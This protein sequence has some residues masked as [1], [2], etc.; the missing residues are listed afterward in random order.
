[1]ISVRFKVSQSPAAMNA[2][3]LIS[4]VK[5]LIDVIQ[6]ASPSHFCRRFI[7]P[8]P[9]V[10]MLA[11]LGRFI[12]GRVRAAVVSGSHTKSL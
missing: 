4:L 1:M 2:P 5:E 8:C 7:G 12:I 9:L 3:S 10:S 6:G 11:A